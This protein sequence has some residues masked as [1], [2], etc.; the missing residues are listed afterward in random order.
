MEKQHKT[1]LIPGGA[2]FIGSHLVEKYLEEGYRVIVLDNLQTTWKPKN[3]ARFF[4]N[5]NFQFIRKDIIESLHF[6][7]HID[8]IINCACA[9]SYTSYQFNPVHT[10]KTNTVGMINLLEL[11]KEKGARILQTST[12]E[13]YGDPLVSPQTEEYRGNTSTLGPRACYDEGKRVAETLCMDYHREYGVD[14]RIV[15]IF[16]TYGE[17]MDVNDGR[18]VTNFV[19]NALTDKDIL[20]Y[21]DG[22]NT[23][24]FQ[25]IDDLVRGLD[26]MMRTDG[27]TGPVNLG[28]P[29]EITMKDLAERVIALTESK[30]K[31]VFVDGATDDPRRRCPDINLAKQLLGWEPKVSLDEGLK[32]TIA[33]FRGVE[34]AEKKVL[35]FATTYYPDMGPAE[36]ALYELS[37]QMPDTEFHIVTTKF[38]QGRPQLEEVG[39]DL[40]HRV[41][42][43]HSIDKYLLPILGMYKAH[44]LNKAHNYRFVWSVMGSYSGIAALLFRLANSESNL[45]MT[46]DDKEVTGS[47]KGGLKAWLLRP[48]YRLVLGKAGTVYVS[49]IALEQGSVL[50]KDLKSIHGAGDTKSF[51][52]KV[53]FSYADMANKQEKKLHR[54]K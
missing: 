30:S 27:I 17:N 14:V 35:V 38:K 41:G 50:L 51:I 49:N 34:P 20:I 46:L 1:I 21:G 3:I 16:N 45:L 5:P 6:A 25:F 42:I 39:T 10:V 28:N 11:A 44:Q 7:E 9:G 2:G 47:T 26:A 29:G 4:A 37:K 48:I 53:R 52:N 43:G 40:V 22:T 24:S 54:P 18:A 32:K 31:L 36:E 33:Y 23:R 19:M 12:S 13:I 8:W 15:R